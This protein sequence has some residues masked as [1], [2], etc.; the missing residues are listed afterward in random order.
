VE[1][2]LPLLR[3]CNNGVTCLIDGHGR[4]PEIFRDSQNSE[5]GPGALTVDVPLRSSAEKSSRTFYNRHG[6][7]FGWSCV[8][9]TALLLIRTTTR[10][11]QA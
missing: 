3:C 5:Y 10:R 7:W 1:N 4:I 6:D 9:I 8:A 2:G 11:P